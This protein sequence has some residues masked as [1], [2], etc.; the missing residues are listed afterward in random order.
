MAVFSASHSVRFQGSVVASS[1]LGWMPGSIF[2]SLVALDLPWVLLASKALS[3]VL[4]YAS[5]A[6][7][8]ASRSVGFMGGIVAS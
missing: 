3:S 4:H 5:L 7:F 2:S 6:V 8:S 1:G